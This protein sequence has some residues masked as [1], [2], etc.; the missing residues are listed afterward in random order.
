MTRTCGGNDV[1]V[2]GEDG[3]A[4]LGA[5]RGVLW[6]VRQNAAGGSQGRGLTVL[7]AAAENAR[8]PDAIP[9]V[10][11]GV[12]TA[13]SRARG[14][15][16]RSGGVE[17]RLARVSPARFRELASP[18]AAFAPGPDSPG[19]SKPD[20]PRKSALVSGHFQNRADKLH[21]IGTPGGLFRSYILQTCLLNIWFL[22]HSV[23]TIQHNAL[24]LCYAHRLVYQRISYIRHRTIARMDTFDLLITNSK[25]NRNVRQ[26]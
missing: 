13:A 24:R 23:E 10:R 5:N 17:S 1:R 15:A 14:A 22:G 19:T 26:M 6:N 8:N 11:S 16:D 21:L 3:G 18:A 25:S 2:V 4:E 9:P 7:A 20:A 12:A